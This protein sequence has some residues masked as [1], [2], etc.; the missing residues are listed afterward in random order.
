MIWCLTESM[1]KLIIIL[2]VLGASFS[3]VFVRL[4]DTPSMVLTF[5]RTLFAAAMLLPAAG[6]W[7]R[8]EIRHL[9]KKDILFCAVSGIF[10]GMHF[11][12]YFESL[13][14]TGIASSVVLVDTEVFFV[15][16]AML[17][18]FREKICARGWLGILLAFAGSILVAMSDA[19]GGSDSL[20]GD[21][22]ALCGSVCM[23]VYTIIGKFCRTHISTTVY[24]FFVYLS[25]AVTVGGLLLLQGIPFGGYGAA[26][27]LSAAGMAVFCTLLGHSIFS[28]GLKY[29]KASFVSTAK[30]LEP[31]FSSILGIFLFSE[32]PAAL[33]VIG[34]AVIIAG[35]FIYSKYNE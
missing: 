25:S 22:L 35:I 16:L 8:E 20:R 29:E 30:L 18:F 34:G 14:F 31:V 12:S 6:L 28:W 4:T 26:A 23:A 3:A 17:L 32:I 21:L 33:T 13:R 10:L 9:K 7:S 5:Y 24:T 1:N 15:A 11:S 27:Y 19:G 2:G